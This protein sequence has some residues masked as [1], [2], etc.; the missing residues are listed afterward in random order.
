MDLNGEQKNKERGQK[1]AAWRC[2]LC[3]CARS[4]HQPALPLVPPPQF[5]DYHRATGADVTIGCLPV[6]AK[7]ASDF[8]LMKIDKD[9][10]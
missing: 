3:R 10:R 6:D 7:R 8:G 2:P 4:L 9:G 5:V 1:R